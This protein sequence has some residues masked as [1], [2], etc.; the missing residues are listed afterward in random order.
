MWYPVMDARRERI[1]NTK[2]VDGRLDGVRTAVELPNGKAIK[3]YL[4]VRAR[5][6]NIDRPGIL[7]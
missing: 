7:A 2:R 4:G 6:G 5:A 3:S 1:G